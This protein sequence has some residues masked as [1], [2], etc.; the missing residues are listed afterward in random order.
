LLQIG[1]LISVVAVSSSASGDAFQA[2][3]YGLS[4]TWKKSG[5]NK[6]DLFLD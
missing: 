3:Q 4:M 6:T 5:I 1:D 2:Y